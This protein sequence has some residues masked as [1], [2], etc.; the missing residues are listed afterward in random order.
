M[1]NFIDLHLHSQFSSDSSKSI[2]SYLINNPNHSFITTEHL[3]FW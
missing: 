2:E 1:S 3:D